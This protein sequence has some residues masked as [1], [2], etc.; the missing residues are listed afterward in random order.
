MRAFLDATKLTDD[1]L[2]SK[3]EDLR[4]KLNI[5]ARVSANEGLTINIKNQ[6]IS[7]QD[8]KRY[9][10]TNTI[11][12]DKLERGTVLETGGYDKDKEKDKKDG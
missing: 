2:D 9:R 10:L 12:K 6:I 4:T 1:E 3:I 11:E 7:L 8:E 5:V